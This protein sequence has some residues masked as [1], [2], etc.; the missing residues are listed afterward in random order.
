MNGQFAR[1]RI[2]LNRARLAFRCQLTVCIEMQSR[3]IREPLQQF[4]ARH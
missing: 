2:A 4:G 3:C 1:R